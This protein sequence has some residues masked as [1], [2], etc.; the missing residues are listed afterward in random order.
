MSVENFKQG[1][2]LFRDVGDPDPPRR[3]KTMERDAEHFKRLHA[4]L[5][6]DYP[7]IQIDTSWADQPGWEGRV[8]RFGL[9][10]ETDSPIE[11]HMQRALLLGRFLHRDNLPPAILK[12]GFEPIKGLDR[13]QII[14]Q[15]RIAMYRADFA[16]CYWQH[17][18][19]AR[20]VVECDGFDFHDHDPERSQKD[21]QRDRKLMKAGWP[22][23]RFAG[24]EIASNALSCASEVGAALA[25]LQW[26]TVTAYRAGLAALHRKQMGLSDE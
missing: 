5:L 17:G 26:D 21:K 25:G 22:V 23:M 9:E 18:T 14:P 8:N 20:V 11:L 2:E 1:S 7:K 6:V 13:V 24:S 3:S 16:V 4:E 10:D 12:A 15:F 19:F